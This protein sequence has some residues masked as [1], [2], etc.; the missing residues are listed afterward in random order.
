MKVAIGIG[1]GTT[2]ARGA[3]IG[4]GPAEICMPSIGGPAA[5]AGMHRPP[6]LTRR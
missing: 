4:D 3:G 1:I 2:G 6:G 5:V